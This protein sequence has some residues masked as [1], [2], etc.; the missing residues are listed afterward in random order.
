MKWQLGE[1]GQ[2]STRAG[3]DILR[4]EKHKLA[5]AW[6]SS[7]ACRSSE[8]SEHHAPSRVAVMASCCPAG[9]TL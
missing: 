4:I 6:Y 9:K 1:Q 3:E 5:E 7:M 8:I 2:V